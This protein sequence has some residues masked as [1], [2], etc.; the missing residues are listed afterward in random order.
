MFTSISLFEKYWAEESKATQRILDALTDESLNQA[1]AKDHRTLGRMAW[2]IVT[3]IPEMMN[4]TGLEITEVKAEAPVPDSADKIK[5]GYAAVSKA[6]LDQMKSR[7]D[8]NTLEQED[9]MYGEKWKKGHSLH[10]LLIHEIHHR[11][12]MTV[13]LR[14]AGLKVPSIYGPAKEDWVKY[15][16]PPPEI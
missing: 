5:K 12:Q 7:W 14:Q 9:E 8:D 16:A 11:G 3:A 13:L 4:R 15:G 2:H 6:L 10:V 1:V